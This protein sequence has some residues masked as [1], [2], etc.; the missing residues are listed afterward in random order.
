MAQNYRQFLASILN[1]FQAAVFLAVLRNNHGISTEKIFQHILEKRAS[2]LCRHLCLC[3]DRLKKSAFA[4]TS[5]EYHLMAIAKALALS[6]TRLLLAVQTTP[7]RRLKT[8]SVLIGFWIAPS[9]IASAQGIA[10]G[11]PEHSFSPI[12]PH[13]QQIVQSD[14]H[15]PPEVA[16]FV[17][18]AFESD[19]SPGLGSPQDILYLGVSPSSRYITALTSTST[20]VGDRQVEVRSTQIWD[21]ENEQEVSRLFQGEHLIPQS[22]SPD[23]RYLFTITEDQE[24]IQIWDI[25]ENKEVF[26]LQDQ[27][28]EIAAFSSDGQYFLSQTL[29]G[30]E[31]RKQIK[32]WDFIGD[33]QIANIAIN[34]SQ[35]INLAAISSSE[36]KDLGTERTSTQFQMSPN[37]QYIALEINN[38]YSRDSSQHY[39]SFFESA[40]VIAW[41][42]ESNQEVVRIQQDDHYFGGI[43]FS[44]N[45]QYMA[46]AALDGTVQI[47]DLQ[48][49]EEIAHMIHSEDFHIR[50]VSFSSD[51]RYVLS[52]SNNPLGGTVS[53]WDIE[54]MQEIIAPPVQESIRYPNAQFSEDGQD[55]VVHG[56]RYDDDDD[57]YRLFVA[58]WNIETRRKIAHI[59]YDSEIEIFAALSKFN[60]D[61]RYIVA[62]SAYPP[63]LMTILDAITLQPLFNVEQLPDDDLRLFS[64]G[65]QYLF[66]VRSVS[67]PNLPCS[68]VCDSEGR[69][70]VVQLW[71]LPG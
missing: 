41:D 5:I 20:W 14:S 18:S 35:S 42:I 17:L 58:T 16:S 10:S 62:T 9:A 1:F 19:L 64:F 24:T 53:V 45:S 57:E 60:S 70:T 47:W 46:T 69:S 51:S 23:G 25:E 15:N 50:T 66:T 49:G 8:C 34:N 36:I 52:R 33:Q 6:V 13:T 68:D 38:Y 55:L 44:P 39:D 43:S 59:D 48:V 29:P 4:P 21:I 2:A 37:G 63:Y 26:S 7:L 67:S 12:Q 65:I 3:E 54:A 31:N 28:Y 40:M 22:L 32:V 30:D 11:V 27:I 71:K 61:S 56:I